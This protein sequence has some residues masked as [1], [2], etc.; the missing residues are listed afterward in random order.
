MYGLQ[1]NP[2]SDSDHYC[3]LDADR[4]LEDDAIGD[5][6]PDPQGG[7]EGSLFLDTLDGEVPLQESSSFGEELS[8][9]SSNIIS[10]AFRGL[11][12]RR[13][14]NKKEG[15]KK[16]IYITHEDFEEGYERDAFLLIYGHAYNL[17]DP[18]TSKSTQE[19]LE[20]AARAIDF[21]FCL[22]K[23]EI[24][25][26]DAANA[27]SGGYAPDEQVRIDVVRL[28]IMYEFW[29]CWKVIPSLGP[30]ACLLPSRVEASA[31]FHAGIEGTI[32]CKQAW[33][34]PG[35]SIDQLIDRT[36]YVLGDSHFYMGKDPHEV[37]MNCIDRLILEYVLSARGDNIY[38]TGKNPSRMIEDR[39]KDKKNSG[40]QDTIWWSK[41]F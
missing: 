4:P 8:D 38:V 31:A 10:L 28:R 37:L 19:Q 35:L 27:L 32:L 18:D 41:L 12:K 9:A 33:Q 6:L 3:D 1:I 26:E 36:I 11:E 24:T 17:F 39:L 40:D 30:L 5:P 29:Q 14:Q 13:G 23:N 20:S 22:S 21:F 25:F 7:L 34:S 2:D 16:E 15:I